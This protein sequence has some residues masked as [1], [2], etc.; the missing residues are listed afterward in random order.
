[1]LPRQKKKDQ[2]GFL[3]SFVGRRALLRCGYTATAICGPEGERDR[4]LVS[5][6]DTDARPWRYSRTQVEFQIGSADWRS[7]VRA[8][9]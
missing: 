9:S 5:R 1:M 4:M 6:E 2:V 3:F 8:S 7:F